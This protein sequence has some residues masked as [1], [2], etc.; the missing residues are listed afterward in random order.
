MENVRKA[1]HFSAYVML[2]RGIQLHGTA[3]AWG[4]KGTYALISSGTGP[5]VL[6]YT[7]PMISKSPQ[8]GAFDGQ[9]HWSADWTGANSVNDPGTGGERQLFVEAQMHGWLDPPVSSR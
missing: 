1:V 9:M 3:S 6:T 2:P 8:T 7:F 5:F 4:E